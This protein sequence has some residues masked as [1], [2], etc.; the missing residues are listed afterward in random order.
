MAR[1]RWN[2]HNSAMT[3]HAT[4]NGSLERLKPSPVSEDDRTIVDAAIKCTE[5]LEMLNDQKERHRYGT[6]IGRAH[7]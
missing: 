6:E 7:V 2:Y 1:N 5:P 4:L 3:F